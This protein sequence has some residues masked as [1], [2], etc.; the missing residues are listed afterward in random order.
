MQLTAS[1]NRT[2]LTTAGLTATVVLLTALASP[3]LAQLAEQQAVQAVVERFLLHLGDHQLDAVANDLAPNAL[4]V[5]TRQRLS[6]SSGRG[7]PVEPR[8]G[9]WTNSYQTRE[10]WLAAMKRNPNPAT[11]REPIT[12]VN[13]TIDSDRLAFVRADFQV[14]RDGKAQSHGVDEFTLVREGSGWKIAVVA[15]TSIPIAQAR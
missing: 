15:Y 2:L 8:D 4:V 3:V 14:V 10:E 6:T 5:V 7:E 11:F 13:V 1:M 12:N 9:E